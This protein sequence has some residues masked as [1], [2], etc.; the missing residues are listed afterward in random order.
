MTFGEKLRELRKDKSL[1]IKELSEKSGVSISYITMLENNMLRKPTTQKTAV[2]LEAAL[3]AKKKELVSYTVTKSTIEL[4]TDINAN[5]KNAAKMFDV[6][7]GIQ[8]NPKV[9]DEILELLKE[10]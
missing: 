10:R 4:I 1:T 3:G 7:N 2:K 8:G 9:L 6:L 5:P